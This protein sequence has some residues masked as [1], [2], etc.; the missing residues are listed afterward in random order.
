MVQPNDV[1]GLQRGAARPYYPATHTSE[2]KLH[3]S[4]R[5]GKPAAAI[6]QS[7]L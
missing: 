5:E 2:R 6:N 7:R 3:R 4:R 1:A